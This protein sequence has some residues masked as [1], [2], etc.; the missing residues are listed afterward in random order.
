VEEVPSHQGMYYV[1][2]PEK[3][4]LY[5]KKVTFPRCGSLLSLGCAVARD[6]KDGLEG[7]K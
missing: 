4:R 1:G 3:Y 6:S 2:L 5:A 7:D